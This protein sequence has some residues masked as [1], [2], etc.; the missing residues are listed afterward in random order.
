MPYWIVQPLWLKVRCTHLVAPCTAL[1]Y[2]QFVNLS[3]K[4]NSERRLFKGVFKFYTVGY[5]ILPAYIDL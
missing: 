3:V 5:L 2:K 1:C 4:Q